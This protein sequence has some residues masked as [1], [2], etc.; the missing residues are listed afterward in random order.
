MGVMAGNPCANTSTIT[1][2]LFTCAC[3]VNN[4]NAE[5]MATFCSGAAPDATCMSCAQSLCP[6]EYGDCQADV[7]M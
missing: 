4:C 3:D 6:T 1:Q 7:G 5:C 2:A